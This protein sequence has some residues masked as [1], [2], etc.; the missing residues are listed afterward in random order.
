[1]EMEEENPPAEESVI[2]YME[3]VEVVRNFNDSWWQ[4]ELIRRLGRLKTVRKWFCY[5]VRNLLWKQLVEEEC[6]S[7]LLGL[8]NPW[9]VLKLEEDFWR[10][11]EGEKTQCGLCVC[12]AEFCIVIYV[13]LYVEVV[14]TRLCYG[15]DVIAQC[16]NLNCY[17]RLKSWLL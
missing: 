7:L 12:I 14:M 1:M 16:L 15:H 13:W 5:G 11:S 17:I 9:R 8:V 4:L 3:V 10:S 6:E 2:S